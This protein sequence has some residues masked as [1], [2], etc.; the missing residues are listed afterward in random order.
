MIQN[1]T[2]FS[3]FSGIQCHLRMDKKCAIH[4][5]LSLVSSMEEDD[6]TRASVSVEISF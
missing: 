1:G 2:G 5:E 3:A 6:A 4:E